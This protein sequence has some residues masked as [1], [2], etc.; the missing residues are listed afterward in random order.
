M[1]WVTKTNFTIVAI[2]LTDGGL[3]GAGDIFVVYLFGEQINA[4]GINDHLWNAIELWESPFLVKISCGGWITLGHQYDR[5][6]S[7]QVA[8]HS[9]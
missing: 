4:I 5:L 1:Y 8:I 2:A 7:Q 6:L 9:N 3:G